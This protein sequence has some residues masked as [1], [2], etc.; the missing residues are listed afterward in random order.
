ME[1][2]YRLMVGRRPM[3]RTSTKT[4]ERSIIPT[5]CPVCKTK[6]RW[7]ETHTDIFC[8]NQR[9]QGAQDQKIVSFFKTLGVD[10]VAAKTVET[11]IDNGMDTVAKIVHGATPQRLIK[12]EGYQ[13]RKAKIISEA[14]ANS[15]K[16]VP[17]AKVMHSSG[18][19]SDEMSSLGS[20]RLQAIIDAVGEGNIA[21]ATPTVIRSK[22]ANV[23]GIKE[24]TAELFI[25]GLQKW[26]QFFEEIK[27]VYSPPSGP[28]TLAGVA[29]C[30]TGFRDDEAERFILSHGGIVKS[31]VSKNVNV[32]FAASLGSGKA[33]KADELQAQGHNISVVAQSDMWAWL[34]S[35]SGE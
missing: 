11:L 7:T 3:L 23:A 1:N 24:R 22:L 26:R 19:F 34:R 13:A 21:R 20:T 9:C 4:P 12:L 10:E 27:S 29:V 33:N 15:L 25:D 35:H 17:L 6:L 2:G 16:G 32:L 30:F 8:P 14:V 18:I 28:K 5:H 31:S